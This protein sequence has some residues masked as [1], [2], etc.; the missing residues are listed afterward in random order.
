M[1]LAQNRLSYNLAISFP[2]PL[3]FSDPQLLAFAQRKNPGSREVARTP[4]Q[5]FRRADQAA[6]SQSRHPA[7]RNRAE[8]QRRRN[9]TASRRVC[10]RGWRCGLIMCAT[11]PNGRLAGQII[12]YSGK[13]GRNPDGIIDN[14]E[15][16]WPETEG[17]EG[18]EQTFNQVLTGKHG[19][20]TK[21]RSTRMAGRLPRK[22]PPRRCRGIPWSR[23]SICV[24]RSSP[25]KRLRQR[26][27]AARLSW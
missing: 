6:L 9:P 11:Y 8:S 20:N 19:A 14:H 25:R 4:A 1:P 13:T 2:T 16:L 3:D 17:R 5:D 18:L 22:S 24:C 10:P 15:V 7:V 23:R 12:G 26:P 21:S 27:S